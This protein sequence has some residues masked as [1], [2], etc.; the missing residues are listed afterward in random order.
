MNALMEEL[1]VADGEDGCSLQILGF[2]CN[3]FFYQEPGENAEE[4]YN[5]LKYC[6]PGSNFEPNFPLM[7]K[8]DVNGAKEDEIFAFLKASC[9]SASGV[10]IDDLNK[11]SWSPVKNDDISWNFEKFL[12]D[13]NGKPYRRYSSEIEPE[14]IRKDILKQLV[15]CRKFKPMW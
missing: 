1:G 2:P 6:R 10:V 12:I 4:I 11:I 9:P 7:Q 3:Q 5:G 8:R 13:S 15:K 14:D